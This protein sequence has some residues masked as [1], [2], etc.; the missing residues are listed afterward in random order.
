MSAK[1]RPPEPAITINGHRLTAAQACTPRVAIGHFASDIRT[2]GLGEDDI[3][4]SIAG[5][6]LARAAEIEQLM[7]AETDHG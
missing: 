1:A 7:L 3:G 4:K 5:G 6:Y 2:D